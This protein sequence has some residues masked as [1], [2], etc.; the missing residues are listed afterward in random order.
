MDTSR[1]EELLEQLIDKQDEL[2]SRIE[3]LEA[4]LEQQFTEAN[5]SISELQSSSSQIYDELNWW[6][7]GPTLAKQVLAALDGIETAV[8]QS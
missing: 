5:V 8:S 1:L 3:S 7:E 2:I 4:T 6:G